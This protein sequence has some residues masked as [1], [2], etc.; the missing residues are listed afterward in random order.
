M[1]RVLILA[2]GKLKEPAFSEAAKEYEKRLGPFCALNVTEIKPARLSEDPSP[3][4]I[5]AALKSEA[6]DILRRIPENAAVYPLC[7]EGGRLSSEQFAGEI[8]AKTCEGKTL[9]FI[10]GGSCGLHESV[11][12]RGKPI[13]FSDMTFPH[14]LFRVML[15][16]QI[17]RAFTIIAGTK[18]H[19]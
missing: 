17:Y 18:Y 10:I 5:E 1:I 6:A 15:L 14:R 16:E 2:V 11:K 3:A 19:K 9:C 12:S 13:S 7:V 8:N 4:E